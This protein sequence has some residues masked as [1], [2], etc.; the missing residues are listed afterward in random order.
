MHVIQV[1]GD[2]N[3]ACGRFVAQR[4]MTFSFSSVVY[5][6]PNKGSDQE[7]VIIK[8]TSTVQAE[9]KTFCPRWPKTWTPELELKETGTEEQKKVQNKK[10]CSGNRIWSIG[11]S[12]ELVNPQMRS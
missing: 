8:K 3:S 6:D 12:F 9:A 2:W 5:R 4:S 10:L 7:D 11:K 1:N